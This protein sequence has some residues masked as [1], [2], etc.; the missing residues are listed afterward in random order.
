MHL[1]FF[2]PVLIPPQAPDYF[3]VV[4]RP[5]D[6]ATV[7]SKLARLEYAEPGA[8]TALLDDVRLI[9]HN[10]RLYNMPTAPVYVSG[11]KLERF[12]ERRVREL[13]LNA[14]GLSNGGEGGGGAEGGG[15]SKGG[16]KRTL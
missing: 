3:D 9:F 2:Y 5:M 15:A 4:A 6:F 12:F 11:Q 7:R 13:K 8:V 16:R 10:C 14:K 1:P